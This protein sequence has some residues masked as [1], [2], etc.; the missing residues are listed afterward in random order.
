MAEDKMFRTGLRNSYRGNMPWSEVITKDIVSLL[1]SL[2]YFLG[3]G[4][5]KP[6]IVASPDLP[7]KRT[8]LHKIAGVLGYRLTNIPLQR[9]ELIVQFDDQTFSSTQ[10][11]KILQGQKMIN[12]NCRDISKQHVDEVHLKVFGYN[13]IINPLIYQGI[14]V[15]KSDENARHDGQKIT[16]PIDPL[17]D[18]AIYQILLDNTVDDQFVVDYRIA[19]I[20]KT[21]ALLYCKFKTHEVRFTNEVHHARLHRSA[22]FLSEEEERLII[23]FCLEMGAEFCELD[24]LRHKAD[25]RIYVIDLNKTPFGPPA[26]LSDLDNQKA[27]SILA[28]SFHRNFLQRSE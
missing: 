7:G 14:A 20:G 23:K 18:G 13:T 4:K 8:T 6:V 10:I 24:V 25:G 17:E 21:I 12:E 9:A 2:Q 3:H 28:E 16:C 26:G 15:M 27:L 22:E 11:P 19:I 5:K 1:K